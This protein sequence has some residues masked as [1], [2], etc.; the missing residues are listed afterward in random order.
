MKV[1][2]QEER[3]SDVI[4]EAQPLLVRHWEET[5]RDKDIIPLSPN[6]ARYAEAES[7]G[8]LCVLTARNEGILVG[9]FCFIVCL[10]LHHSTILWAVSDT[11]WVDPAHRSLALWNELNDA[12]ER[13]LLGR[14]VVK[15]H[16]IVAPELAHLLT[17]R[18][19]LAEEIAFGKIL[20]RP[21]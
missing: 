21:E 18:G 19:Y 9:Y 17:R 12:S 8:M 1:T 15:L 11:M 10:H 13:A 14:G 16:M 6:Y 4:E 5:G 3:F 7:K 20:R 2:I